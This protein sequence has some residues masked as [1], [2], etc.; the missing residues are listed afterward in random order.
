ME[1]KRLVNNKREISIVLVMLELLRN[2]LV[3]FCIISNQNNYEYL[4]EADVIGWLFYLFARDYPTEIKY[5]HLATRIN[6]TNNKYDIGMGEIVSDRINKPYVDSRLAAEV[7]LFP[8]RGFVDQQHRR[9]F[10]E[11]LINDF[12]KLGELQNI[13]TAEVIMDA[14]NYLN[15]LYS[16]TNRLQ[17]LIRSRNM[18]TPNS[19]I[20]ICKISKGGWILNEY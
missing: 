8:V 12:P 1:E 5:I 6:H 16:R 17:Y 20:F 14:K 9:R 13:E 4:L 10:A 18:I 15:G 3:E 19:K 2:V 11:I 7:K